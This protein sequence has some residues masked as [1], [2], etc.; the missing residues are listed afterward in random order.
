MNYSA[1]GGASRW[2]GAKDICPTPATI[3]TA[4]TAGRATD[5]SSCWFERI[6][7]ISLE[8]PFDFLF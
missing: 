1:S 6:D 2:A 5:D 7:E 4:A 8:P 3:D